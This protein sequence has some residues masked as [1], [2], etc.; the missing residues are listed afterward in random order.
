LAEMTVIDGAVCLVIRRDAD[1]HTITA[2]GRSDVPFSEVLATVIDE[3]K[4]APS[5]G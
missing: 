2:D 5:I 3:T 1:G 4:N